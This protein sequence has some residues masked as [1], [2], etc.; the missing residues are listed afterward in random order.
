MPALPSAP[1]GQC[2]VYVHVPPTGGPG[3]KLLLTAFGGRALVTVPDGV[4]PGQLFIALVPIPPEGIPPSKPRDQ[5]FYIDPRGDKQ[6]P[7]TTEQMQGW[8]EYFTPPPW[9]SHSVSEVQV[10]NPAR[11][12]G[13]QPISD[14]PEIYPAPE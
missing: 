9:S 3:I 1:D 12:E 11:S 8:K 6:G 2:A 7:H 4:Q 13:W 10:F 14:F 5:W